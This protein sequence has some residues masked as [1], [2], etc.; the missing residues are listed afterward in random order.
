M[1]AIGTFGSSEASTIIC[2]QLRSMYCSHISSG[3]ITRFE[4]TDLEQTG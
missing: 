1:N 2:D 4:L 3:E